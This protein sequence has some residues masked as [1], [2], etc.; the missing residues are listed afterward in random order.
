MDPVGCLDPVGL[1]P[2]SNEEY[3]PICLPSPDRIVDSTGQSLDRA[4]GSRTAIPI[5]SVDWISLKVH[6]DI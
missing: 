3:P 5:I 4:D 1:L 6:M 2:E